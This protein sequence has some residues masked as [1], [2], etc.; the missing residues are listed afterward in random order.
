MPEANDPDAKVLKLAGDAVVAIDMRYRLASYADQA[1]MRD[2]RDS[3]F[4]AYGLARNKLLAKG[5]IATEADVAEMRAI[6]GEIA[7]AAATA[8]LIRAIGKIVIKL[9][10]FALV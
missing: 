7:Q 8:D 1:E 5:V 3:A 2:E 10:R 9:S 6:A 4:N